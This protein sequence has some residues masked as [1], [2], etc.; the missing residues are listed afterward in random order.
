MSLCYQS[1]SY[2]KLRL[3]LDVRIVAL[4]N[5]DNEMVFLKALL[6]KQHYHRDQVPKK[7]R[8]L[9]SLKVQ[10]YG[11]AAKNLNFKRETYSANSIH[12]IPCL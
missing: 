9:A 7:R 1:F 11:G 10:H 8:K 4:A 6:L 3:A 2:E 12:L 5:R